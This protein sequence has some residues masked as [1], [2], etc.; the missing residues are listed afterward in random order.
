MR[1]S[2][3]RNQAERGT[4]PSRSHHGQDCSTVRQSQSRQTRACV[5]GRPAG[6]PSV[7][8]MGRCEPPES[9]QREGHGGVLRNPAELRSDNQERATTTRQAAVAAAAIRQIR[10]R[11]RPADRQRIGASRIEW[12]NA[13]PSTATSIYCLGET[14]RA[15]LAVLDDEN[16]PHMKRMQ[17]VER[18]NRLRSATLRGPPIGS[19][20]YP[21]S[22]GRRVGGATAWRGGWP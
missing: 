2:I 7:L 17:A 13:L 15:V 8:V 10:A 5:S 6:R 3:G 11:P 14:P 20:R 18:I 19:P 16:A 9:V 21:T 12:T 4:V 22:P 1:G